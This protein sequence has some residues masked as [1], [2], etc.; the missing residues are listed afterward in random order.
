MPNRN[1]RQTT[2][3]AGPQEL[4]NVGMCGSERLFCVSQRIRAQMI[5][6]HTMLTHVNMRMY[7]CIY[8]IYIQM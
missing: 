5:I 2:V 3:A 4:L 7:T 8:Y 1:F 6:V